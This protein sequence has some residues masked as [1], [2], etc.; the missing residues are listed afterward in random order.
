MKSSYFGRFQKSYRLFFY[1]QAAPQYRPVI[2]FKPIQQGGNLLFENPLQHFYNTRT[3]YGNHISSL[4]WQLPNG[5]WRTLKRSFDRAPAR[6]RLCSRRRKKKFHF[7]SGSSIPKRQ[8]QR[9]YSHNRLWLLHLLFSI[10]HFNCTYYIIYI[11][12]YR[13]NIA[14]IYVIKRL[15]PLSRIT[16]SDSRF[17]V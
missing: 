5:H 4:H 1:F 8:L 3:G 14:H 15:A 17:W 9:L 12:K 7:L 11:T 6:C 10:L 16:C 2:G 13:W